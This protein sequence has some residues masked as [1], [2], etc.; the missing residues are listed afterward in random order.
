M[1]ENNRRQALIAACA[2]LVVVSAIV[3]IIFLPTG[4]GKPPPNGPGIY[5]TGPMRSKGNR[6]VYGTE[7]GARVPPPGATSTSTGEQSTEGGARTTRPEI[8]KD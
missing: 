8:G 2:V 1:K 3:W 4:H 7:D 6:A 5:Y